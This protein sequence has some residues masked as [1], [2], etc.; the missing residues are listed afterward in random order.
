MGVPVG[1]AVPTGEQVGRDASTPVPLSYADDLKLSID[2]V[3]RQA[4]IE[5]I[6]PTRSSKSESP[7]I[8]KVPR[9]LIN[10][11]KTLNCCHSVPIR[12]MPTI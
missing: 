9:D 11:D 3:R 12:H 1:L 8:R 6:S 7:T 5:I 10:I 4:P 2:F